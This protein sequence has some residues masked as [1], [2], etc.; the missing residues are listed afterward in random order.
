LA[1]YKSIIATASPKNHEYLKSLGATDVFDYS[2]PELSSKILSAAGGKPLKYAVDCVTA[3]ET[4]HKVAEVVGEGS[5]V[6]MLLPIKEGGSVTTK[7]EMWV[8][9]PEGINPF[10]KGVEVIGTRTFTFQEVGYNFR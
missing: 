7:G 6:S 5:I 2:D 1:G 3:E 10:K 9:L 8:E 4:L